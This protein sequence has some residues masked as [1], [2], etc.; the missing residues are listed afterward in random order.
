[1]SI[2]GFHDAVHHLINMIPKGKYKYVY[3]IPRGGVIVAVYVSHFL[4][5]SFLDLAGLTHMEEESDSKI[6]VV[7]DLADTGETLK[8]HSYI[9]DT[10]TIFCKSRSVVKP[11]Y[12][13]YHTDDWV[14]FPYENPE[15]EPNREPFESD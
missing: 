9:Y 7:D 15:E 5:L 14:V 1:M 10:A 12:V 2:G 3:G 11:T 4:N 6:L 8:M 13:V